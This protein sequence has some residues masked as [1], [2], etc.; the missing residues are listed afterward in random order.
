MNKV[1]WNTVLL[2]G[3]VPE[4]ELKRMIGNSYD[5]TKP[6]RVRGRY[7][8]CLFDLDGTL[9][10]PQVGITK[11]YQFAL[12]AFGIHEELNNLTKFIG[13]PLRDVF[14]DYYGFSA[15][16]TEKLVAKF[17]E[18]FSE[19]GLLENEVY[20]EIRE[21]LARLKNSGIVM[22][23]AT[24]KV[25][26]YARRIIKHFQ[27][28]SYFSFVSG[29]D[30]DGSQTKEGKRQIIQIALDTLDPE[31]E[32][33][34]VIIGDRQHDIIGG[35]STGIESIGVTW[36]Y[37]SRTELEEAGATWIVDSPNDLCGLVMG[38]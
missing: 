32:M 2:G 36:G 9:T 20:P 23:V 11:S 31:H 15:T 8:L 34:P 33:T 29:D 10:D 3:D 26:V 1:H 7:N 18:Y 16:D 27:L 38:R 30:M 35:S 37:G 5:L 17:R 25:A 6:K 21:M 24:S 22:A 28:D 13:P 4:E 14:K 12:S 19:T